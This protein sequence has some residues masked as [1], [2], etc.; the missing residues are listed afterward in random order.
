[1]AVNVLAATFVIEVLCRM[2]ARWH[3][4][5]YPD[6][7]A[8][9]SGRCKD[10]AESWCSLW[11]LFYA[12]MIVV[13]GILL[14]LVFVVMNDNS[15]ALID[16]PSE[17]EH[18]LVIS[19]CLKVLIGVYFVSHVAL[20]GLTFTLGDRPVGIAMIR[21]LARNI[22]VV[23]M[24]C[25]VFLGTQ[26][27]AQAGFMNL[28]HYAA[29]GVYVCTVSFMLQAWLAMAQPFIFYYR[30]EILGQWKLENAGEADI[31]IEPGPGLMTYSCIRWATLFCGYFCAL[32]AIWS[33]CFMGIDLQT[34]YACTHIAIF[35]IL[36]VFYI[37]TEVVRICIAIKRYVERGNMWPV[38]LPGL[39]VGYQ[40]FMDCCPVLALLVLAHWCE[41]SFRSV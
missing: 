28:P 14:Y 5:P 27:G 17:A 24:L 39:G 25:A 30:V 34:P 7:K 10:L 26:L 19:H 32:Q 8:M 9:P 40:L 22:D 20:H 31:I 11:H 35:S 41:V 38:M 37:F 12:L 21:R 15:R 29:V 13:L 23:P 3:T 18:S 2:C 6:V 1:M 36:V 4:W 33:L 16:M